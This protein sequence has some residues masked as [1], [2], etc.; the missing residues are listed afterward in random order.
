MLART[1]LLTCVLLGTFTTSAFS[2][3]PEYRIPDNFRVTEQAVSLTLDPDAD[4]YTG[5]TRLL[6]T[7]SAPTTELKLHWIDLDVSTITLD[8]GSATRKLS[9]E[10][11][12]WDMHTLSDGKVIAPGNYTLTLSFSG[13]YSTDALGLYKATEQGH[14]YLF[15]QFEMSLARRAFPL[16]DEPDT[17]IPWALT[18][19]APT[20]TKVVANTPVEESSEKAGWTTYRFETSKPMPSYL[21]AMAVGDFDVTPI[22]G[23]D[24]P[25][26]IYSPRGTADATGF[27]VAVTPDILDALETYFGIPYPYKK[28]DFVAVPNFTFGAME[29]V[30]LITYR[31]ELLLTGDN[32]DPNSAVSTVNVIAHELAHQ[33]YGNL[34]TMAWW[35]ELWLNEAFASWMAYKV[36]TDLHPQYRTDLYLPQNAAFAS[37]ALG[38]SQAIRREVKTEEDVLEGLGLNYTKGNAILNMLEQ[39]MGPD[40]FRAGIRDYMKQHQWQNT[41]ADD[42]W[43]ALGEHASFDVREIAD[44]F[45]NQPGFPLIRVDTDGALSQTRFENMGAGLPSQTWKI[46]MSFLVAEGDTV[47]TA[48]VTL[49]KSQQPAPELAGADWL[50]PAAGGNGYYTWYP[51]AEGY[52]SL[53][54][55]TDALTDREKLAILVNGGQLLSA[56]VVDMGQHMSLLSTMIGQDNEELVLDALE[57]IRAIAEM[58]RGTHIEAAVNAWASSQLR[59]WYQALGASPK[60]GDSESQVKLRARILRM[61]AQ[62]GGD[63]EVVSALSGLV[64]QYFQAPDSVDAGIALEA[65]RMHAMLKGD[66]AVAERYLDTYRETGNATV[67]TTI[68]RAMYF[69][70][71]EAIDRIVVALGAGEINAGDMSTVLTGLFYANVDQTR[72]YQSFAEH[73]EAIIGHLPEFYVPY[74]PQL[75]SPGCDLNSLEQLQ[76]FYTERGATFATGL[77]KSGE[78]AQSCINTKGEGLES[79]ARFLEVVEG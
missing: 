47:R 19:S 42:L 15:T 33:W 78:A 30:G 29:N 49:T 54:E 28:L 62:F 37:D 23:L 50:L 21:I 12:D 59:P 60:K 26:H 32:P 5:T 56:G 11:G 61:L 40:A 13:D 66:K 1:L 51:G 43:A 57:G 73:A 22:P 7:V 79:A 75:T 68:R 65:L 31:S 20:D 64:D 70:E 77:K 74:L 24:V 35:D 14:N 44:T 63:A 34:V 69:T 16:V 41:V 39:A 55:H 2:A 18:I 27:S 58:Y 25:A 3:L 10:S 45:L 53:L 46:P 4:A 9:S 38:A 6:L 48:S 8:S 67:K 72:L 52:A 76:S 17:K 71:P 36:T